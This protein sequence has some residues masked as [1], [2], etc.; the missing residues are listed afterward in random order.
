MG[1]SNSVAIT[2]SDEYAMTIKEFDHELEGLRLQFRKKNAMAAIVAF[3]RAY[4]L[5]DI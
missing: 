4:V 3:K 1:C 5:S 2:P